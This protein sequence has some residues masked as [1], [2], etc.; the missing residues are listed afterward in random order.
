M[1]TVDASGYREDSREV[2]VTLRDNANRVQRTRIACC[3]QSQHIGNVNAF[4]TQCHRCQNLYFC[5]WRASTFVLV[6]QV[7]LRPDSQ[8]PDIRYRENSF[9]PQRAMQASLFLQHPECW[10]TL[11][12]PNQILL[13]FYPLLHH[14]L[15]S[16][17]YYLA[18][19][20]YICFL[21]DFLWSWRR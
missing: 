1:T 5:T 18:A 3:T 13:G 14:P 16:R 11:L 17:T 20:I 6:K 8:H 9:A 2:K 10:R 19:L 21:V 15:C 12:H 7:Y 4:C